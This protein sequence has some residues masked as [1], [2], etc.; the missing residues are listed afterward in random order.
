MVEVEIKFEEKYS[1][2]C[3]EYTD[4]KERENINSKVIECVQCTSAKPDIYNELSK[5]H[6]KIVIEFDDFKDRREVGELYNSIL[7]KLNITK[8]I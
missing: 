2:M 6:N 8:C 1:M 7:K 4:N 5:E 3:I